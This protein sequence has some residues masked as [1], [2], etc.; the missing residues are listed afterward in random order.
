M[1]TAALSVKGEKREILDEN[2]KWKTTDPLW[3]E[4]L[5]ELHLLN[6]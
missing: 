3:K 1:E 2:V 6:M 4:K 5:C